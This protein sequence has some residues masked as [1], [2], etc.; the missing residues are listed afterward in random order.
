MNK[1]DFITLGLAAF[2]A[3]IGVGFLVLMKW[4]GIISLF[5]SLL[6]FAFSVTLVIRVILDVKHKHKNIHDLDIDWL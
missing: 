3:L 2:F 5:V 1:A 4:F 6:S